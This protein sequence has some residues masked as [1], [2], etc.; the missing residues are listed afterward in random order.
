[1]AA[2]P[3]HYNMIEYE[4]KL[5]RKFNELATKEDLI[6]ITSKEAKY[7]CESMLSATANSEVA[8]IAL[9]KACQAL[10][11]CSRIRITRYDVNSQP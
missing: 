6:D 4:G 2:N 8:K 1:M 10:E 9:A 11:V 7:I 5:I 3:E